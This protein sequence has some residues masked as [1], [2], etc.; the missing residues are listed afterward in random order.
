MEWAAGH[1]FNAD[2]LE[3]TAELEGREWRTIVG[4]E[5]RRKAEML[6]DREQ[7]GESRLARRRMH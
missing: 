3:R 1:E 2:S 7:G 6:E 4:L 5:L